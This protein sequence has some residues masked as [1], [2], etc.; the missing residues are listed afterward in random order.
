MSEEQ[1]GARCAVHTG[2]GATFTCTRCGTFGCDACA[3][4]RLEGREI[5]RACAKEGL[6]EPIPWERRAD[7]GRIRAFWETSKILLRSPRAFYKTPAVEDGLL[8]AAT[9]GIAVYTVGQLVWTVTLFGF[10]AI[11]SA[12]IG[13]VAESAEVGGLMA[14]YS[15]CWMLLAVPITLGQAPLYGIFGILGGGGL[16]HL[17]LRLFKSARVDFQGTLRAV[18]YA[19]A[20]YIL[21]VIPLLGIIVSWFW[22]LYLEIVGVREAHGIGTD[23]AAAAVLGWRIL[24][25]ALV[26]GGYAA[27]VAGLVMLDSPR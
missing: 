5:C 25:I 12:V 11:A 4:S 21:Y 16:T 15:I 1:G 3:F 7:V 13:V 6:N 18:S 2:D 19:N 9:Y 10:F 8:G 26:I 14:G 17:S 20:P 23:R 22:V 27:L 24:L